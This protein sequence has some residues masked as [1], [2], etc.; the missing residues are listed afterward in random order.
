MTSKQS[1][2]LWNADNQ[3]SSEDDILIE[4]GNQFPNLCQQINSIYVIGAHCYEEKSL[5]SKLFPNLNDIYLFEPIPKIF[6]KLKK[7]VE[8]LKLA[9]L[10]PLAISD[11]D[12]M[13]TF[14][15]ASNYASS[16][17]LPMKKHLEVFP[18]VS[19]MEDIEVQC[20]TLESV[21]DE[22]QLEL[23]DFLF[24]DVQGAEYKILSSLK[25]STLQSTKV[26]YTEASTE[27]FYA[28]AKNLTDLKELLADTHEFCGYAPLTNYID[29]HGNAIFINRE[30][31]QFDIR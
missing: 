20:R 8:D 26:I 31:L 12:E 14:H 3:V 29:N 15:I 7:K 6:Q 13:A 5:I 18:H 11:K 22:Y 19:E 28:G 9:K 4:F 30:Y 1:N 23:P 24:I 16:S 17:L 10:F 2:L 25:R 21:M 27:E